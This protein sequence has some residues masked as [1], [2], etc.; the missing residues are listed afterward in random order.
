MAKSKFTTLQERAESLNGRSALYAIK[1]RYAER[2]SGTEELSFPVTVTATKIAFQRVLCRIEPVDGE[3]HWW[4]E[5]RKLA[6]E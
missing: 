6:F 4:V 3:G 5:E 1:T 2:Q